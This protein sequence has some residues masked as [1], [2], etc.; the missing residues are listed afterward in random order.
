MSGQADMLDPEAPEQGPKD[1]TA[2]ERHRRYRE[3]K[4]E[5]QAGGTVDCSHPV[6]AWEARRYE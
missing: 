2:A 1:P 3:K 5:A 4:Q 6:C